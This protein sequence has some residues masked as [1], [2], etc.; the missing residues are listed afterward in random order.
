MAARRL[1]GDDRRY[2]INN[3]NG[4]QPR[5]FFWFRVGGW[6]LVEKGAKRSK[7]QQE[8]TVQLRGFL[9]DAAIDPENRVEKRVGERE[10]VAREARQLGGC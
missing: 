5:E 1:G 8:A 10:L 3:G 9:V 4:I 6:C 7:Q 2:S